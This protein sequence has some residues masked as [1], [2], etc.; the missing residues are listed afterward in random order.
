MRWSG[1][2]TVSREHGGAPVATAATAKQNASLP[3]FERWCWW[4][5]EVEVMAEQLWP[6]RIDRW[7]YVD[8]E[9]LRRSCGGDTA[10]SE[11]CFGKAER[12]GGSESG[13]VE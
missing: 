4:L 12:E 6:R 2:A 8:G 9:R 13:Q 7:S 1:R 3:W 10:S 5:E 11:L